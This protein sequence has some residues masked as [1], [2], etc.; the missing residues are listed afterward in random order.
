[1]DQS[2]VMYAEPGHTPCVKPVVAQLALTVV[3]P[4]C[5]A[6]HSHVF[7]WTGYGRHLWQV[8]CNGQ[9]Y[10]VRFWS[11]RQSRN[12]AEEAL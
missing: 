6:N 2:G 7:E 4:H 10:I 1:M 5:G 8:A 3:C 11:T 9:P 12:Q